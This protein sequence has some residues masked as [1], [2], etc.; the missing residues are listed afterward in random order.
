[1]YSNEEIRVTS[2]MIL[3][4]LSTEMEAKYLLGEHAL[5]RLVGFLAK[6]VN[7]ELPKEGLLW[8]LRRRTVVIRSLE[9]M[10]TSD[11]R[12][13]PALLKLG[14]LALLA[15]ALEAPV[16]DRCEL[17]ATLTCLWT[18]SQDSD[19]LSHIAANA[20]L[21]KGI[22]IAQSREHSIALKYC[23]IDIAFV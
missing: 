22:S 1:M 23:F 10:I 14:L 9:K 18:L 21:V 2:V 20:L 6:S 12:V 15:K 7:N 11:E 3:S 8:T 17:R 5:S 13:V 16:D 4:L 19:A